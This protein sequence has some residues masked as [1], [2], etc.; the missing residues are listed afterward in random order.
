[1]DLIRRDILKKMRKERLKTKTIKTIKT[2]L[3]VIVAIILLI[4]SGWVLNQILVLL[5][6]KL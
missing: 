1:M 2:T 5:N 3:I 4:V 6:I